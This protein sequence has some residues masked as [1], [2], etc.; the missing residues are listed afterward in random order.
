M[1][2]AACAF[3]KTVNLFDFFSGDLV[4]QVSGHS[5]LITSVRFSPDGRYL[6]SVGGDGCV[7]MWSLADPLVGAM[8]ER[9]L[10]LLSSAQ[11]R[12]RR[13]SE[14]EEPIRPPPSSMA[15]K[16]DKQSGKQSDKQGVAPPPPP[17]YE[18][19]QS[20]PQSHSTPVAESDVQNAR[21]SIADSVG[22]SVAS[23]RGSRWA[24]RVEQQGGYEIF[25]RKMSSIAAD[26][27]KLTLE[28]TSFNDISAISEDREGDV[29]ASIVDNT[30][31]KQKGGNIEIEEI[32]DRYEEEDSFEKSFEKDSKEQ[33]T[34]NKLG[35]TL[36]ASD[37]VACEGSDE[38]EVGSLFKAEIANL[39]KKAGKRAT[40]SP[41][42]SPS[43]ASKP[44]KNNK[45]RNN[46]NDDENGGHDFEDE[47]GGEAAT[48]SCQ[49]LWQGMQ[50]KRAFTGFK[51]QVLLV[52]A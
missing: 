45:N 28:L 16:H 19:Y 2:V 33:F 14:V 36:E 9:L 42:S 3:D 8:Q 21:R 48:N 30:G 51:F 4:A 29:T 49:L 34:G 43:S 20:E 5:D 37:D 44:M 46:E 13:M 1:F 24:S 6:L 52:L 47:E 39:K 11:K 38:D 10:E 26:K 23:G 25:G 18:Q 50:S 40:R 32:E 17:T 15:D 12:Q 22:A 35:N 31:K 27:H 41:R 7:M